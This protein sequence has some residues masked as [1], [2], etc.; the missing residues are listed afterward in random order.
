MADNQKVVFTYRHDGDIRRWVTYVDTA[1]GV[2]SDGSMGPGVTDLALKFAHCLPH[3]DSLIS[4]VGTNPDKS[5]FASTTITLR[6][7]TTFT[8]VGSISPLAYHIVCKDAANKNCGHSF[9]LV[10]KDDAANNDFDI[11]APISEMSNPTTWQNLA[12]SIV[13]HCFTKSGSKYTTVLHVR[14]ILKR[15]RATG[16]RGRR[17]TAARAIKFLRAHDPTVL[18]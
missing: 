2:S 10:S 4:I 11:G 13:A 3:Q 8:L 18:V 6:N 7:D 12:D 9:H 17:L 1:D 14:I 16:G 5:T 15:D